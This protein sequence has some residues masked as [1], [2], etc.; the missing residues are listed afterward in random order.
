MAPR[1]WRPIGVATVLVVLANGPMF[2][3]T[4]EI[5]ARPGRWED[6]YV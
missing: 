4:R 2:F 6:P 3:V 5:M 1:L